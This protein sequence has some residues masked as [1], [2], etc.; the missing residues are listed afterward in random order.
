MI[1]EK[2]KGKLPVLFLQRA[3]TKSTTLDNQSTNNSVKGISRMNEFTTDAT[4]PHN[5]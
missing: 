2:S 4:F 3:K 5:V 1:D